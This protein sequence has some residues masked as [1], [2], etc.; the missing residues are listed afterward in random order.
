M[1]LYHSKKNRI[2]VHLHLLSIS[3]KEAN[4]VMEQK[5]EN[6]SHHNV[7]IVNNFQESK[8]VK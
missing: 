6:N 4:L 8:P 7:L 3:F 1:D 2:S 5:T